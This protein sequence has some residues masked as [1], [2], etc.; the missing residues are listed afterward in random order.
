MASV[1][2]N[3]P[4]LAVVA[5][6]VVTGEQMRDLVR[7][8]RTSGC[9]ASSRLA[10]AGEWGGRVRSDVQSVGVVLGIMG[11][12]LARGRQGD[13]ASTCIG[14][15]SWPDRDRGSAPRLALETPDLHTHATVANKVRA[16]PR[17]PEVADAQ[18]FQHTVAISKTYNTALEA[19]LHEALGVDFSERLPPMGVGQYTRSP[20]SMRV[21]AV[22]GLGAAARSTSW[23]NLFAEFVRDRGRPEREVA[24]RLNPTR[25][26]GNLCAP[27]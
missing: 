20:G 10:P 9:R 22:G 4:D 18:I 1:I 5:G 8:R 14:G 21:C 16:R 17:L 19:S 3:G 25:E 26:S 23:S 11:S 27:A 2:P 24:T 12:G 6:D 7:C 15:G 13:R